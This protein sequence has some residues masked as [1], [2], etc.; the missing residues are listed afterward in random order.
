[1]AKHY[2]SSAFK[3]NNDGR[4]VRFTLCSCGWKSE[5]VQVPDEV[6]L[7]LAYRSNYRNVCDDLLDIHL[8]GIEDETFDD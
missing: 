1:M 4:V 5:E 2:G 8:K 3:Y 6:S 7:D